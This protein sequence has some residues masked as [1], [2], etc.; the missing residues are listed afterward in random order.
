MIRIDIRRL[1]D[2]TAV[3]H[4]IHECLSEGVDTFVERR[5]FGRS[6]RYPLVWDGRDLPSKAIAA[7]AYGMQFP[8]EGPITR[9][10]LSG[11]GHVVDILRALG[12][13]V[14]ERS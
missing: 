4:A 2:R 6:K 7:A 8:S 3:E 11:G 14:R 10:Q 13:E 5:G 9:E 12:F 1:S